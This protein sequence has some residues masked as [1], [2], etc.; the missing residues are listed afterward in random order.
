MSSRTEY[1]LPIQI[2]E[3]RLKRVIIDQ[4]Y[5]LDHAESV[6]DV[7]ILSLV[8]SIDGGT[9]R[10]DSE[11]YP[12]QYLV[13]DPVFNMNQPYRLIMIVC[14]HDDYLEVINAF[15]VNKKD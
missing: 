12:F 9:F 13:A 15:R 14:L 7:L 11:D 1:T 2:N 8:K 6:N 3:R 4:H 5:L 10:I